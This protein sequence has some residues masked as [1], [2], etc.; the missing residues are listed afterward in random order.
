[1]GWEMSARRVYVSFM[2]YAGLWRCQFLE[3]DLRTSLPCKLKFSTSDKVIELIQRGNG[4][5][6][7]AARQAVEHAVDKGRGGTYLM[8]NAEQYEKLK[9]GR[10]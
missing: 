8:L 3:E 6:D 1:M 7:L 4:I 10:K 2:L 9:T 5:K